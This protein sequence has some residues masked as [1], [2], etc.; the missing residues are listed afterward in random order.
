M[1]KYFYFKRKAAEGQARDMD[2]RGAASPQGSCYDRGQRLS[3]VRSRIRHTGFLEAFFAK[4]TAVAQT[5][6]QTLR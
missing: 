3:L 2:L 6:C 4:Q 1:I 5:A